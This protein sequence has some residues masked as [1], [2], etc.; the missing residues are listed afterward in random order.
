MIIL[1]TG[2]AGFLGSHLCDYYISHNHKIIVVDSLITGNL[3]NI[4]HLINHPNFE[5]IYHDITKEIDVK[6][7]WIFN[8]ACPASPPHYQINPIHTL[9]TCFIGSL[10]MLELARKYEA[11]IMQ[12]STSEIYGD[13][14]IHPQ[15]ELYHGNV[16]CIGPRS[17][18]DE[19][20]RVAET[21][22]FDFHRKYNID[23]RVIR[24]FN[25]Y[26]PK[27]DKN[28]GRVIS[29]FIMQALQNDSI[30]IYGDGNQTRSFC[31]V[32]DLI[33]GIDIVMKSDIIGPV[34]L[35]NPEE[36]N[37]IDL[38]NIIISMTNSKSKIIFESLP[39]DDP[40]KRKPDI[41]MAKSLGFE[42]SN[43]LNDGLQKTIEYFKRI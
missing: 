14:D 31:Y 35:G 20:K 21:L 41:S 43:N 36:Y 1:I 22:F 3:R 42:I 16:N 33:K 2:G 7:D 28:D 9:K 8:L 34:N 38:A 37:L 26:G 40:K 11:R 15:N 23:I 12:F 5:F 39:Q 17:C 29:N 18:Y 4:N 32:D 30:T 13:P 19:G 6:C 10:N 24:I 27:M 25:T